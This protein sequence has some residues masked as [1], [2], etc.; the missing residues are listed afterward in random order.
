MLLPEVSISCALYVVSLQYQAEL[1]CEKELRARQKLL[2]I[3]GQNSMITLQPQD[4]FASIHQD[5]TR[6]RAM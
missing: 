1:A 2:F 3:L 4:P 5:A 6:R